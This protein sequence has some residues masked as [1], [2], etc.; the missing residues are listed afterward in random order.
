MSQDAT[1]LCEAVR[2]VSDEPF[3]G[4]VEV[5]L[6]DADGRVC[7]FLDKP[8]IFESPGSGQITK[9]SAFPVAAAL[10]VTVV[11]DADPAVVVTRDVDSDEG[12]NRFRVPASALMR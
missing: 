9:E 12:E 7:R 8:P 5:V 10:R 1:L 2:W 4:S 11:E 3:P 6:T